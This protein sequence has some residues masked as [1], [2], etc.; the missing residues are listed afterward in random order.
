MIG[1]R[2]RLVL[3]SASPRRRQLLSEVGYD[4]EVVSPA[5]EELHSERL[6]VREATSYNALRKGLAV[7]RAHP[8]RVVLAADTLVALDHQLIG[9]PADRADA[10][11]LLRLLSDRTH[12]VA[13]GVF[14][15]HLHRGKSITFSVLSRVVFKKLNDRMIED[16]LAKIDPLDK[17]GGY[18][19]QGAGGAIIARILGSRS[20][21]I[22]LPLEKTES[23]LGLFEIRPRSAA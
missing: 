7:A 17:A 18:A 4:F 16:Y 22:G 20:N 23:A 15:A 6:T 5:V 13:T 2:P 10:A 14:I 8:G 1:K 12:V 19:A 21:V 9:K 11:A 3:A